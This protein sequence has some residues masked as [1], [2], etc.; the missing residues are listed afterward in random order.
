LRVASIGS[1]CSLSLGA[2]VTPVA[3]RGMLI[4][5]LDLAQGKSDRLLVCRQRKCTESVQDQSVPTENTVRR[6]ALRGVI[7]GANP[8]WRHSLAIAR[9]GN[10]G[11]ACAFLPPSLRS[12]YPWLTGGDTLARYTG[13]NRRIGL[14]SERRRRCLAAYRVWRNDK[15]ASGGEPVRKAAHQLASAGRRPTIIRQPTTGGDFSC[16][17]CCT[18]SCFVNLSMQGADRYRIPRPSLREQ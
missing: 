13:S 7:G 3:L 5:Y 18:T 12:R 11:R 16:R 17:R 9:D 1:T 14:G 6:L 10:L 15:P 8:C 4:A 2:W